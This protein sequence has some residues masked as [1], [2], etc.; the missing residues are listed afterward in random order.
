MENL[1]AQMV[2]FLSSTVVVNIHSFPNFSIEI[3]LASIVCV[4]HVLLILEIN[5]REECSYHSMARVH[6]AMF[7]EKIE[8][9][10]THRQ[11]LIVPSVPYRRLNRKMSNT[12]HFGW[13]I[14]R[15]TSSVYYGNYT[16]YSSEKSS[17]FQLYQVGLITKVQV[18][19][20]LPKEYTHLLA[21]RVLAGNGAETMAASSSFKTLGELHDEPSEDEVLARLKMVAACFLPEEW[22]EW[23]VRTDHEICLEPSVLNKLRFCLPA[24]EIAKAFDP[25]ATSVKEKPYRNMKV[26]MLSWPFC[27]GLILGPPSLALQV[28][29][30]ALH[31]ELVTQSVKNLHGLSMTRKEA[32]KLLGATSDTL[33][34]LEQ[35]SAATRSLFQEILNRLD[36]KKGGVVSSYLEEDQ[37]GE[38]LDEEDSAE[39][40]DDESI[41]WKAPEVTP[42]TA[43][44]IVVDFAPQTKEQEPSI[45]EPI[46]PI[47][48][49]GIACQR[50][51]EST[52]NRIRYA[53]VQK[54]IH[55]SP[56]F[57]SLSLNPQLKHLS[58]ASPDMDFLDRTEGSYGTIC[59]G[60]LLQ[61]AAFQKAINNILA[62][63]PSAA[64]IVDA[65]LTGVSSLFRQHSDNVLQFVCGK[66]AE[67]IE[68]RRNR[69]APINTNFGLALGKIPPP[70]FR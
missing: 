28:R 23:R 29:G 33:A 50:L 12:S 14:S 13:M 39:E 49:Q 66:R 22:Q 67:A 30:S 37:G 31:C 61:R 4:I 27:A 57:G 26:K 2:K 21:S 15:K 7:P 54:R 42:T 35:E 16:S 68:L 44:D 52:W 70:S 11:S 69:L 20:A 65:E 55:A 5:K 25:E 60:L 34:A 59:H 47:K 3:L 45:P 63:C 40:S 62:A 38:L 58:P 19:L 10:T 1:I 6:T 46:P 48:A 9:T 56:V 64:H 17:R 36:N 41:P 43:R 53:D 24:L 18:Q 51:G 32:S 8:T